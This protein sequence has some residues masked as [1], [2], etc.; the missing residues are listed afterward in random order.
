MNDYRQARH[1]QL[2]PLGT[3]LNCSSALAAAGKCVL[4][5]EQ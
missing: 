4:T 2:P 5:Q 1:A 3:Y